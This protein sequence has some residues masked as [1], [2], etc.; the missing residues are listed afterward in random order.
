MSTRCKGCDAV[1]K[2]SGLYPHLRQSR[3]PLCELYRRQ[4][5]EGVLFPED[6]SNAAT[7]A[8][9]QAV[10]T[11]HS[12]DERGTAA[13]TECQSYFITRFKY[14]LTCLTVDA[15]QGSQHGSESAEWN[16]AD[17]FDPYEWEATDQHEHD[18]TTI[19]DQDEEHQDQ[20]DGDDEDMLLAE[21]ARLIEDEYRME[22]TRPPAPVEISVNPGQEEDLPS[23]HATFR[24]RGG[25]EEDLKS[26]PFVVKFPGMAGIS[27]TNNENAD[28]YQDNAPAGN[29]FAPF[30]SKLDWEVARW[31]KLRGPGSTAFSEL[32]GIEGVSGVL[33]IEVQRINLPCA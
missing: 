14:N 24:L 22:A 32:M 30:L 15:S 11:K 19:G 8:Q 29:P 13:I 17:I 16:N 21:D 20:G 5:D 2:C 18:N 1:I 7:S 33:L 6:G 23:T 4:L 28:T 3:N 10:D 25:C 9:V 27:F 12:G 31:A 26:H